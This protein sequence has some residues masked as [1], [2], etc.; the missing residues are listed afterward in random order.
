MRASCYVTYTDL[1]DGGAESVK[2][3]ILVINGVL[4]VLATMIAIRLLY[5]A[6][7]W[8][9]ISTYWFVTVVKNWVQF[10]KEA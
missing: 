7:A 4:L 1:N 6:D 5:H 10:V 2:L 9:F 3:A 8:M